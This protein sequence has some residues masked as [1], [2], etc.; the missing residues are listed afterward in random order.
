MRKV[1]VVVATKLMQN[2][3]LFIAVSHAT[4]AQY[5]YGSSIRLL[6]VTELF[7]FQMYL[8]YSTYNYTVKA[9]C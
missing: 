4:I 8:R 7:L 6:N 3:Y 5:T 1:D 9:E 2:I